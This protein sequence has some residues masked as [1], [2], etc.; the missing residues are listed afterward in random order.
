MVGEV[1]TLVRVTFDSAASCAL[2]GYPASSA[3]RAAAVAEEGDHAGVLV[4]TEIP[5]DYPY[6]VSCVRTQDGWVE[7]SSGNG[8]IQ[9]GLTDEDADLGVLFVWGR[10]ATG[11][12]RVR[13]G[14]DWRQPSFIADDGYWLL[15][16]TEQPDTVVD[17]VEIRE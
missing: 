13:I 17:S 3:P 10:T 15:L 14:D 16:L 2:A 7:G 5:H 6:L 9:W 11:S 4:V 8:T 1:H 12:P